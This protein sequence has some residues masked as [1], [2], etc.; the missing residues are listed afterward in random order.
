MRFGGHGVVHIY[1]LLSIYS[2]QTVGQYNFALKLQ[3]VRKMWNIQLLLLIQVPTVPA[4]YLYNRIISTT[5][6]SSIANGRDT[7]ED[8]ETRQATSGLATSILIN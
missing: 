1:T 3:D 8:S 2:Y 5:I 6:I 7:V 4:G